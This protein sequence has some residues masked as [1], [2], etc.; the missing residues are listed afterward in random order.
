MQTP[1]LCSDCDSE[2]TKLQA[3]GCTNIKCVPIAGKPGFCLLSWELP[4][5]SKELPGTG[6]APLSSGMVA[7]TSGN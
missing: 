2:K 7:G 3:A 1:I 6:T 5:L 4:K